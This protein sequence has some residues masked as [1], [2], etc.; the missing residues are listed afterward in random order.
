MARSRFI[1]PEN[2]RPRRGPT[3]S[4]AWHCSR[5]SSRKACTFPSWLC[6]ARCSGPARTPCARSTWPRPTPSAAWASTSA[7]RCQLAYRTVARPCATP[8]PHSRPHQLGELNVLE[9][10]EIDALLAGV[11]E[12]LWKARRPE[13]SA[14]PRPSSPETPRPRRSTLGSAGL[15]QPRPIHRDVLAGSRQSQ[16]GGAREPPLAQPSISA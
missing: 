8:H 10:E 15:D 4:S 3:R 1:A 16:P 6:A 13:A 12:A 5:V 14:K 2:V 7:A 9:E 11:H